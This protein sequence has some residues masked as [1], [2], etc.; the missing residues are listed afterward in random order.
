MDELKRAKQY[1]EGADS[2]RIAPIPNTACWLETVVTVF[3]L[4]CG[5]KPTRPIL[6]E[7]VKI[8]FQDAHTCLNQ[9]NDFNI[10][11]FELG[12]CLKEWQTVLSPPT[13]RTSPVLLPYTQAT[14]GDLLTYLGIT[15]SPLHSTM[16]AELVPEY[17]RYHDQVLQFYPQ[18]ASNATIHL[19][20]PFSESD[21]AATTASTSDHDLGDDLKI[22][23]YNPCGYDSAQIVHTTILVWFAGGVCCRVSYSQHL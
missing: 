15:L 19:E 16:R 22:R 20:S 3:L 4:S 1:V 11:V 2:A 14:N 6:R 9:G 5:K 17:A 10:K 12:K 8:P 23:E 18:D 13:S 7:P 21:I